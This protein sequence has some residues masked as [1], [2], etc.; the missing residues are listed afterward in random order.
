M[1]VL[2]IDAYDS[3]VYIV[4]NYMELIGLDVD[5]IRN[6]RV[7]L[8]T[9]STYQAIVLGPGPGHPSEC[10][11]FE[12]IQHAEGNIPIFGVCLGMQAIAEFYG[13]PVKPASSRQHGKV[14]RIN[15]DTKGCFENLPSS[16]KVTR[17]HSLVAKEEPFIDTS[18]LEVTAR[19]VKDNYIMGLRHKTY[20]IEGVQFHPESITTEYGMEIISNFFKRACYL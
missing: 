15:N 12:I 14:S 10:G 18:P 17:Y 2:L 3:F 20:C 13:I 5:I 1:K 19:S 9:L 4:K 8:S 7:D 6:D 11:Y 16:F